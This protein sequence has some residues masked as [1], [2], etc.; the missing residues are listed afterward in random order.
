MNEDTLR[1]ITPRPSLRK[2]K[3]LLYPYSGPPVKPLGCI[4]LL[5]DRDDCYSTLTF[6]ITRSIDTPNKPPLLSGSDS[7]KLGLM[8]LADDCIHAID[9]E[10]NDHT[11]LN[12]KLNREEVLRTFQDQFT[13]IGDMG[14]IHFLY[15]S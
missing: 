11:K 14:T 15:G 3:A 10:P 7:I 13:G 6:F 8:G 5:C 12:G 9:M 1:S 2:T 4:D